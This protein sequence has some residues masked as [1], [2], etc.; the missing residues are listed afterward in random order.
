M[1]K[2]FATVVGFLF[3]GALW[4]CA[5]ASLSPNFPIEDVHLASAGLIGTA[6]TVLLTLSIVPAQRAADLFSSA[7]LRLYARDGKLL[8]LFFLLSI[9]TLFSLTLSTSQIFN[10]DASFSL[11][12]QLTVL[13]GALDAVRSFYL[14]TLDLL[15][16]KTAMDLVVRHCSHRIM[17]NKKQI[18]FLSRTAKIR[19]VFSENT[20][21]L[22]WS[23]WISRLNSSP[24]NDIEYWIDNLDEFA[25]KSVER[26][27][28]QAIKHIVTAMSQIGVIYVESKKDG[29]ILIPDSQLTI[30]PNT[31]V[32]KTL[33]V[34]Y[35][36]IKNICEAAI[37]RPNKVIAGHCMDALGEMAKNFMFIAPDENKKSADFAH[38]PIFY[39]NECIK[40]AANAAME[41]TLIVASNN[42]RDILLCID[43]NID[44]K[45]AQSTALKS[46][47][48]IAITSYGCSMHVASII[49]IQ[50]IIYAAKHDMQVNGFRNAS[51]LKRA[52]PHIKELMKLEIKTNRYSFVEIPFPIYDSGYGVDIESI[53]NDVKNQIIPLDEPSQEV[54]PFLDFEQA[55][56]LL[57]KHFIE[58][59]KEIK[60]G[61]SDLLSL[62]LKSL[63]T[64]ADTH[65]QL[66]SSPSQGSDWHLYTIKDCLEK[67]IKAPTLYFREGSAFDSGQEGTAADELA[68]L[69]LKLLTLKRWDLAMECAEI[70]AR[71]QKD[72]LET[73]SPDFSRAAYLDI[74]LEI[75][76]RGAE[77]FATEDAAQQIRSLLSKHQNQSAEYRRSLEIHMGHLDNFSNRMPHWADPEMAE[78]LL[79]RLI[80]QN[81]EDET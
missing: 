45:P 63:F 46:L 41:D 22:L 3:G 52:L 29:I 39:L 36:S 61:E 75:L 2:F 49:A 56:K 21:D 14:R 12:I 31:E 58:V 37:D 73:D 20:G 7:V 25:H 43:K 9:L 24:K 40:Y 66:L 62:S 23:N 64:C 76:A 8:A 67:L 53:L 5:P 79:D 81:S 32:K 42:L 13:G 70:I 74:R 17:R 69:G 4:I 30:K 34:I 51:I 6:L 27:D 50:A 78:G 80:N 1:F 35:G 72:Y 19:Y 33:K 57:S 26:F 55:S 11:A 10:M 47:F 16:P 60:F 77:A 15:S 54:N 59:F 38:T 18:D 65:W 44:T 48:Y 68:K 71:I 28:I